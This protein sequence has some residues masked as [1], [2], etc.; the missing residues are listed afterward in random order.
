MSAKVSAGPDIDPYQ[1]EK[2]GILREIGGQAVWSL[3][4][5]KQG[6][7]YGIT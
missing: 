7:R 6:N 5:C 1:G 3:S 4:S 2:E